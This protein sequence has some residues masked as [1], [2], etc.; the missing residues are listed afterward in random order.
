[1]L[2]SNQISKAIKVKYGI[3]GVM[4][5]VGGGMCSFYSDTNE[6]AG[7]VICSGDHGVSVC[8]INHLSLESWLEEF[9][10]MWQRNSVILN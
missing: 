7:S 5:Y 10:E 1:M 6:E 8:R 9:Y 4:V 2:T 3:A